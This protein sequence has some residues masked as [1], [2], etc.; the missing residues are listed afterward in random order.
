VTSS[1]ARSLYP[2]VK[3]LLHPL[4]R[5]LDRLKNWSGRRKERKSLVVA[6]TETSILWS[7]SPWLVPRQITLPQ[8]TNRTQVAKIIWVL[9]NKKT[10]Y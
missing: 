10:Y 4:D 8:I 9:I 3:Y 5:R 7:S 1:T 2:G 6:G